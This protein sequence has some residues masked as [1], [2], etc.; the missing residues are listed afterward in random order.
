NDAII[1]R[2][3]LRSVQLGVDEQGADIAALA[4][5]GAGAVIL[6]PAH[7]SPTGVVLGPRRRQALVAWTVRTGGVVIEDDYDAEF[8]YDR[9][10]VGSLQ[11]LARD[12]VATIGS[13]SKS[14]AP[15]IRLGWIVCPPWLT[16]A[17]AQQKEIADR[18][19]PAL[20]QIALARLIES[21]RYD[22]H[23]R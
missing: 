18:G 6:T 19:S 17:V 22:R 12:R 5:S 7:Q 11:G 16:E 15:G 23:L 13:V 14:L 10:P 4:T 21:G 9:Q 8:R 2:A 3:G 20:D 1:R